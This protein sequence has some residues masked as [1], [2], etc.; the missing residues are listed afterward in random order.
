MFLD[1]NVIEYSAPSV[2]F[3]VTRPVPDQVDPERVMVTDPLVLTVQLFAT[4]T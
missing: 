4:T 2:Q 1:V 3:A